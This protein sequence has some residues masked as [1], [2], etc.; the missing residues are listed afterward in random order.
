[1][2]YFTNIC[3]FFLLQLYI[4]QCGSLTDSNVIDEFQYI[5]DSN[6]DDSLKILFLNDAARMSIIQMNEDLTLQNEILIP[7]TILLKY[8]GA[9]IAVYNS[10]EEHTSE[11]KDIHDY[12]SHGVKRFLWSID[13]SAPW[14]EN[15][16]N[17][18]MFT[19]IEKLDNIITT[20]DIEILEIYT[21]SSGYLVSYT[22]GEYVNN[23]KFPS[24]FNNIEYIIHSEINLV[25]GDG[26]WITASEIGF[27]IILTYSVGRGDCPSGCDYRHYWEFLVNKN[28]V[29]FNKE[30]GDTLP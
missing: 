10:D 1:M 11:V 21:H 5:N 8:Y 26:D 9:L 18:N 17:D 30:Y 13:L 7:D 12:R 29:I 25:I 16:K 24:L 2:K 14:M 4:F 22:T 27:F 28:K 3:I 6:I 20:Y 19:G 15:W 23:K